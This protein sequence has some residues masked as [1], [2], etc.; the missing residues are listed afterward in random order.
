MKNQTKAIQQ[1]AQKIFKSLALAT[2]SLALISSQAFASYRIPSN[3]TLLPIGTPK[4]DTQVFQ[5]PIVKDTQW[6]YFVYL[7]PTYD[8][9]SSKLWPVY[10]NVPAFNYNSGAS[11]IADV[12]TTHLGN[13]GMA[14]HLQNPSK[15]RQITN[16]FIVI[17]PVVNWDMCS[18]IYGHPERLKTLFDS[19]T[20]EFKIDK[21]RIN[22]G[23]YCFGAGVTYTFATFYPSYLN[24]IVLYAGNDTWA[25]TF[26][27]ARACSLKTLPIRQYAD[28]SSPDGPNAKAAWTAINACG[29]SNDSITYGTSGWHEIWY[30]GGFD[31]VTTLFDWFLSGPATPVAAKVVS[32]PAKPS[33]GFGT[34]LSASD[35][36][37]IIDFNGKLLCSLKGN[38]SVAGSLIPKLARGMYLVRILANSQSVARIHFVK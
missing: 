33:L 4:P 16:R 15:F 2:V 22:M 27:L 30:F 6:A 21:G 24:H 38:G 20:R 10:I 11:K 8:Q 19:L 25:S 32:A 13:G 36:M 5:S 12:F 7:P 28:A 3:I 31:T 17:T 29:N 9:N 23:G 35:R 1:R 34:R 14:Q 37:E 18:S 26:N